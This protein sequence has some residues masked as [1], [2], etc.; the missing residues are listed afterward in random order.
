MTSDTVAELI[1]I[2]KN[3]DIGE[4]EKWEQNDRGYCNINFAIETVVDG[5]RNRYFLRKYKIGI[6]E[7]EIRFE[8]SIINHLTENSFNLTARVLR[9][10]DGRTYVQRCADGEA[11]FYAVFDF[12]SGEDRYTWINPQCSDREVRSAASILARLHDTMS[13]FSPQGS[14]DEPKIIELLPII[15]ENVKSC[16]RRNKNTPFDAHLVENLDRIVRNV[17]RTR[18]ALLQEGCQELV[19]VVIHCDYHPGNLKFQGDEITG[20]FDFDWSKIDARCFDVALTILYFFAAWDED[21]DGAF[22]LDQAALFLN[23]Y[24]STLMNSRGIGPL[25]S[26]ELKNLPTMVSASNLYVLNWTVLDFYSKEVDADEYLIYLRHG[27][28]TMQWL[29]NRDNWERLKKVSTSAGAQ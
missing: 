8:H 27:I 13:G 4:L 7:S 3:Y 10:R 26:V 5:E 18:R 22:D 15:A 25:N 12:L 24:Q 17:E 23:A 11:H 20:L 28:R 9:T 6:K 16:V 29:E 19:Q 2:L 14:R 1:E 21:E